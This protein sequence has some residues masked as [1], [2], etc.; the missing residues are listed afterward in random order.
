MK[1]IFINITKLGAI[2]NSQI[3]LKPLMIFSGESGLGKSYAAF[4]VHYVYQILTSDRLEQFFIDNNIDLRDI[5]EHKSSGNSILNISAKELFSWINKDA[6]NYIGYLIGNENF[7]GDVEINF[8]YQLE[9]FNFIYEDEIVGLDNHED[10]FYKIEL[11]RFT[12]RILSNSFQPSPELFTTLIKAVL[13]EQ[14]WGI[15]T[16]LKRCYLLPP[17]RGALMELTER[18]SFRS[19]M[20]EEFFKLKAD[21][22]RPLPK[23]TTPSQTITDCLTEVNV[24]QLQQKEG[25]IYYRTQKGYEMPLTAAASSIKELA[26]F[27][28]L[29]NKFPVKGTSILFEEPEAHLHPERQVKIADLITCAIN[30]GCQMQITTH[31]DYLLKRIN[32][33]I[34]LH[35]LKTKIDSSKFHTLI[36]DYNINEDCLI[37]PEHVGAFLLRQD[38]AGHST[39]VVQD[40]LA[41]NEIP[42]ESFYSVIINDIEL[43]NEI[44]SMSTT[45]K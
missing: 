4:L 21:L 9:D 45:K 38:D 44:R 15:H 40:I 33:L 11:G 32:N 36:K 35:F 31:S 8:P 12:Y 29:L 5:F 6:I 10:L 20:Y 27:T 13:T 43:S 42:F 14:I 30:N 17:S 16:S 39:I 37:N 18:T 3:E 41:D 1:P 34:K 7:N 28:M 2:R 26:P 23:P 24:G 19:G 22:N 25:R